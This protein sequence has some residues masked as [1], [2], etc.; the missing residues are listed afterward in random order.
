MTLFDLSY[1]LLWALAIVLIPVSVVLVYL[2]AQLESQ[3]KR[4]GPVTATI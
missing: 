2:L 1:L 3:S 4:E